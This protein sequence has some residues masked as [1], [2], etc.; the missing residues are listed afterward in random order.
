M[1]DRTPK[2]YIIGKMA[3]IGVSP[4]GLSGNINLGKT[5]IH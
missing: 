3:H 5:I 4:P 2:G 1:V